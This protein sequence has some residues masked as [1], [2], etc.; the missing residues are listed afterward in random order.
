MNGSR[1]DWPAPKK[2]SAE[3]RKARTGDGRFQAQLRCRRRLVEVVEAVYHGEYYTF[4]IQL[5]SSSNL[6]SGAQ[7]AKI[8]SL[9]GRMVHPRTKNGE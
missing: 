2:S 3:H 8:Y 9:G 1:P 7:E 5:V 4:D 6:E